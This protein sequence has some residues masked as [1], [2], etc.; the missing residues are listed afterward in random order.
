MGVEGT[1]YGL[2]KDMDSETWENLDSRGLCLTCIRLWTL[3][4]GHTKSYER[5]FSREVIQLNV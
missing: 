5:S 2:V 3:S 4:Y 1:V